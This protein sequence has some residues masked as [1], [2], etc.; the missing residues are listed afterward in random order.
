MDADSIF[1]IAEQNE[2]LS[3]RRQ[4]NLVPA[5][6]PSEARDID[7][8]TAPASQ[9]SR[10]KP[11]ITELRFFRRRSSVK[12]Q[13]SLRTPLLYRFSSP[14]EP[15]GQTKKRLFLRFRRSVSSPDAIPRLACPENAASGA[16]H[17]VFSDSPALYHSRNC[18]ADSLASEV[19]DIDKVTE[20]IPLRVK[21][22][23]SGSNS[24]GRTTGR[25][26][27]EAAP[28]AGFGFFVLYI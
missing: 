25:A 22:P 23:S 19:C 2:G 5:Y 21:T 8:V 9:S 12:R 28:Y 20:T 24:G 4:P 27:R 11:S 13:L 7:A 16:E 17:D 26:S 15:E 14:G 10:M 18:S 6:L 1:R 3:A